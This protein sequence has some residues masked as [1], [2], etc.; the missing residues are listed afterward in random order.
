MATLVTEKRAKLTGSIEVLKGAETDTQKR[1]RMVAYTGAEFM[2]FYGRA[3]A[4]LAGL[5]APAKLPIL[6]NHDEEAVAGYADSSELTDKGLVLEGPLLVDE[7]AGARI[8]R[9][10]ASGFP[11]TASIGVDITQVERLNEGQSAKCNGQTVTGPLTI[12]RKASLFET[13][14]V[15]SNPADKNTSAAA[16]SEEIPMTADE[17]L[18]ANPAAVAAW[19]A[20]GAKVERERCA[21]LTAAIKDRP[22][23]VLAQFVAGA[24]VLTAKAALSDVLSAEIVEAKKAPAQAA[25]NSAT[26][27]ALKQKAGNPGVGFDGNAR[28]GASAPKS[29]EGL[30]PAERAKAELDAAPEMRKAGLTVQTL[31]RY[32]EAEQRGQIRTTTV[33]RAATAMRDQE[34]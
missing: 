32:Y 1:F 15:T 2:R 3:V 22:E 30:P 28:E 34:G 13:S 5:S 18:A 26:L 16:L 24:D 19:K 14:F 7:P 8:A 12:W 9:L 10:S 23:F 17:F 29:F 31:T 25:T 20:E 27:D 4:D 11:L 6:V 21:D 33:D